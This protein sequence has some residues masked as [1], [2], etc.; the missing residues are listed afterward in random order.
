[1]YAPARRNN[2]H[3]GALGSARAAVGVAVGAAHRFV[4]L[5][6]AALCSRRLRIGR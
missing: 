4:H 1:L 2:S 6:A 5:C 3:T